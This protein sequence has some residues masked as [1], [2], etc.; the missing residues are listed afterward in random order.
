MIAAAIAGQSNAFG[1]DSVARKVFDDKT[2]ARAI[3]VFGLHKLGTGVPLAAGVLEY[4][5]ESGS[6][7]H[8]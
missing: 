6:S 3:V 7:H 1:P 8:K 4:R 2:R 5:L